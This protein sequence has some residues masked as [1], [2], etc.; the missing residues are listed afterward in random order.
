MQEIELVFAL[1]LATLALGAGLGAWSLVR[2]RRK[3]DEAGEDDIDLLA[4]AEPG[5]RQAKSFSAKP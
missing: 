1:A 3:Q 2:T 5:G 4:R